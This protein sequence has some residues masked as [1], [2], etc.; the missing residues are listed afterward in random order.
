MHLEPAAS[1]CAMATVGLFFLEHSDIILHIIPYSAIARFDGVV[2]ASLF[3][4][5]L[6]AFIADHE[7]S[8][9]RVDGSHGIN[10]LL[11]RCIVVYNFVL[12]IHRSREIFTRTRMNVH[13][14]RAIRIMMTYLG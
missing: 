8:N 5:R 1:P 14:K 12:P 13:E 10:F 6:T 2:P 4:A 11:Y 9:W 3:C 7:P